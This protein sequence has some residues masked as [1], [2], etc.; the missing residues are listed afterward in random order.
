MAS[1][2]DEAAAP[3]SGT[4]STASFVE[5]YT[6]LLLQKLHRRSP[7]Q[8]LILTVQLRYCK[9]KDDILVLGCG[10]S[11]LSADLFDVGHRSL[12][13]IDLSEVVVSQMNRQHA[14]QG[15]YVVKSV[16]IQWEFN[17]IKKT[18]EKRAE[19]PLAKCICMN[20]FHLVAFHFQ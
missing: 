12:V 8:S 1:S 17:S 19:S 11:T 20:S 14:R 9:T 7:P 16:T 4:E 2:R 15:R 3:L 10:N 13:S 18:T 6:G 5:Y